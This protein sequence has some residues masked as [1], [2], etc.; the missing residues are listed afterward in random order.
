[1]KI[2]D[3]SLRYKIPLLGSFIILV[4]ALALSLTF[5]IQSRDDARRDMLDSAE[6]LGRALAGPLRSALL[7]DDVWRGYETVAA[8]RDSEAGSDGLLIEEL[9]VL[10]PLREIFVSSRPDLY[11]PSRWFADQGPAFRAMDARLD[12]PLEARTLTLEADGKILQAVPLLADGIVQGYLVLVHSAEFFVPRFRRLATSTAVVTGL[13]LAFLLPVNWYWGRRMSRP[14]VL[15]SDRM[16]SLAHTQPEPLPHAIYPYG[17]ELGRLFDAYD[18]MLVEREIRTRMEREIVKEGRLAA[19]GRL[20][21]GI[22]HEINNPLG[23][24]MT[25]VDTLKQYGGQDAVSLRVL[26]LLERGL[27]QIKDVVAALLV[28]ARGTSRKLVP[29]DAEDAHTL[30]AEEARKQGVALQWDN[31]LTTGLDLPATPVR[32]VLINLL[33]N[34]IQAAGVEGRVEV[35]IQATDAELQIEIGNGGDAIP[36]DQLDSLFEPFASRKETGHGLGLWISHQIVR[37]L[38]GRIAVESRDGWTRF[39]VNVPLENAT[40]ATA[41]SA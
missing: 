25:A 5:L 16:N 1:M 40:C 21:A 3:L 30:L 35:R 28:E 13:A 18:R 15:L 36:P 29:Q 23:G 38:S 14:L 12:A 33:L 41:A 19:L 7:R 17:D 37:Q 2:F 4:T 31:R 24:L 6:S 32:Q 8:F 39:S 11:P 27:A 9:I 10:N 26:P 34:A 20:S 22:A